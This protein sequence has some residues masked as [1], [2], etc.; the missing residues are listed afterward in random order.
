MLAAKLTARPGDRQGNR[1]ESRTVPGNYS[2]FALQRRR[3][4]RGTAARTVNDCL[5]PS[6][7]SPLAHEPRAVEL[8]AR[9]GRLGVGEPTISIVEIPRRRRQIRLARREPR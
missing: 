6:V 4:C 8:L 7:A 3:S 9:D 2:P 5:A 1:V